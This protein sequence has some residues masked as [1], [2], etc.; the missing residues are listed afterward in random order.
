MPDYIPRS[1]SDFTTWQTNFLNYAST[2]A[3]TLSLTPAE[4][5]PLLTAQTYWQE[6]YSEHI[7]AQASADAALQRKNESREAYETIIR[8]LVKRLQGSPELT[9]D[10]RAAMGLS[11]PSAKRTAVPVPT[12]APS[13]NVDT[14]QRLRHTIVF[15]DGTRTAKPDGVRGCEIWVKLGTAPT[16]PEELTF[17]GLDTRSPYMVSCDGNE[18]GQ[19]AHYMARWSN[20]R[21][22]TAPWSETVSA[23]IPS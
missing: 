13:L 7:E 1:D 3:A 18:A 19:M 16:D 5:Q 15:T 8:A 20:T 2:N 12:T 9:N 21:G 14:S 17:L 11:I 6:S 4:L 10:Q 23:T 22:E